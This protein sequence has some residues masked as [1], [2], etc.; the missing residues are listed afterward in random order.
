MGKLD[1]IPEGQMNLFDFMEAPKEKVVPSAGALFRYL[2][3][4]PHT[5]VPKVRE[6]CKAYLDSVNGELPQNFIEYCGNPKK[7]HPL[8]CSNCEYG[9]SG[10]CRAG[11]HTCHY[12][13][14]ILICDAFKQTIVGDIP[15]MPCD[16]CG[17]IKQGCCDYPCT[18]DD[19]CVLGDKWIPAKAICQHSNHECNKENLWEVADTL[20]DVECP[21][22]CCRQC[23]VVAC[24]ARCN[25][26]EE[27]QKPE[28]P[29]TSTEVVKKSCSNCLRHNKD[30]EQPPAGWG[31]LGWC[32][33]HNQ[34]T[35]DISYCDSWE[36]KPVE[37]MSCSAKDYA[38]AIVKHL[39]EHCRQWGSLDDISKLR[40]S[41]T[42]ATFHKLFCTVTRTYYFH[43]GEPYFSAN[44]TKENTVEIK[45]CG[46][47]YRDRPLDATIQLQDVLDELGD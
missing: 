33:E 5:V 42:P 26:S 29:R 41:R 6:E 12:E 19:Y 23:E 45:R 10:T 34:K 22:V 15:D 17:Y 30:I 7:W 16:T 2:R 31:N 35:K 11:G 32:A 39:I 28:D 8:P 47:D 36:P 20:D 37:V 13:Y 14:G 1:Y 24:G 27:P 4:G 9:R 3:Y 38:K 46:R 25:G 21:H 43:M 44:F 40:E 18:P